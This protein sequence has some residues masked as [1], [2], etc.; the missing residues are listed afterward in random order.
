MVEHARFQTVGRHRLAAH[1]Q[2]VVMGFPTETAGECGRCLR[3]GRQI[4]IAQQSAAE[5]PGERVQQ[6]TGILQIG[7]GGIP[8]DD[9]A[10]AGDFQMN[11]LVGG[12]RVNFH[13]GAMR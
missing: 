9:R 10:V 7:K 5:I 4:Q 2:P 3:N 12:D 1:H 8:F 6:R 11:G 13:R